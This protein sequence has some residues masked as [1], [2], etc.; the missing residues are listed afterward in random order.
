MFIITRGLG[1]ADLLEGLA[2]IGHMRVSA[3]DTTNIFFR[4][5]ISFDTYALISL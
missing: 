5:N 2:D 3:I 1:I 4:K